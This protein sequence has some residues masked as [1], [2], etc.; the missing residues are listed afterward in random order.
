M[1]NFSSLVRKNNFN[2]ILAASG[3]GRSCL[4]IQ[5]ILQLN[6]TVMFISPRKLLQFQ[7]PTSETVSISG[8][9]FHSMCGLQVL[10]RVSAGIEVRKQIGVLLTLV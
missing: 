1:K 10:E 8:A 4:G 5:K 2:R 7:I 6:P 9:I 3:K